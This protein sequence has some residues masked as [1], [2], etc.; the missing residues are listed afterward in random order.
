MNSDLIARPARASIDGVTCD[1]ELVDYEGAIY[2]VQAVGSTVASGQAG[3]AL[4]AP[5][6]LQLLDMPIL[7]DADDNA[8][9]YAALAPVAT[10]W[11]G[12]ALFVGRDEATLEARG[13]VL[14]PGAVIGFAD[15]TLGDWQNGGMDEAHT[16]LVTIV[17][18]DLY[19]ATR[20]DVLN[21]NANAALLGNEVICF[22]RATLISGKQYRL[23]GLMR[24]LRGTEGDT[25]SHT[26]GERFVLL[27]SDGLTR[28]RYDVAP[29]PLRSPSRKAP[30]KP[31]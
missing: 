1:L 10:G 25:A 29:A 28:V 16:V 21:S 24:G 22:T 27:Q 23:S 4:G 9:L 17:E 19:N 30:W 5:T 20:D 31:T 14:A 8:G 7:R 26:G 13:T 6:S 18:G 11:T 3:I 15:S 2:T 12:A